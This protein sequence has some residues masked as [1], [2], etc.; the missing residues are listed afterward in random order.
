MILNQVWS[1]NKKYR[2]AGRYQIPALEWIFLIK[3]HLGDLEE[4]ILI[5]FCA[6]S[7]NQLINQST[8]H[9]LSTELT[10]LRKIVPKK[11]LLLDVCFCAGDNMGLIK[12]KKKEG[13]KKTREKKRKNQCN[14]I[15]ATVLVKTLVWLRICRLDIGQTTSSITSLH[16]LFILWSSY[17]FFI[18]NVNFRSCEVAG[19]HK[20]S[21][22]SATKP[23]KVHFNTW[24]FYSTW[25]KCSNILLPLSTVWK[26]LIKKFLVFSCSKAWTTFTK[27]PCFFLF[28]SNY[29][30]L[31]SD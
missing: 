18:F 5:L 14:W 20:I 29:Q 11:S 3:H 16:Q 28:L 10:A 23:N 2:I 1:G 7:H 8:N 12:K 4:N 6:H 27:N 9:S 22:E 25:E 24:R 30:I 21:L 31:E 19:R 13:K 26:T 17:S 15:C